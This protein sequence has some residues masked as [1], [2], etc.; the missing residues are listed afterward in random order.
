MESELPFRKI[1][2]DS[3]NAVVGNESNFQYALPST[4]HL[5]PQTACYVLD[6]AISYGF[7]TV[8]TGFNDTVYLL[9]RLWNGS[10]DVTLVK[11][12][13]IPA[14]AYQ[15]STL[16][17]AIQTSI[18]NVSV[19]DPTSQNYT[20]TYEPNTNSM[21]INLSFSSAFPGYGSYHG[22]TI[23]TKKMLENEA[24]Q[25]QIN[26]TQSDINFNNL[27][28]ASGLLALDA[29]PDTYSDVSSLL[30]AWVNPSLAGSF[31][32]S[33]KSGHV[34]VRSR[35]CLYIHSDSLAGMR[36]IGCNGSRSVISRIPVTTTFGGMLFKEH[37][38]HPLDFIPVGGRTLASLDFSVRDSFG[39]IVDLH[40]GH[41]SIELLFAPQPESA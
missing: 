36:T 33:L 16:A 29:S 6:V 32:V 18:N 30:M 10:Q 39:Q 4:L 7:W 12:A 40:R 38:S 41:V 35:H 2:I 20:V 25:A 26:A 34:D 13:V 11:K 31:P 23:L 19:F 1:I 37:S 17:S 5:P 14:G 27:H 15:P 21:L 24:V 9:E 28:D 22:F 3:R 8:E